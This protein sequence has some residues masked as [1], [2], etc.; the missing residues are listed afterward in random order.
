MMEES[1][2]SGKRCDRV[3]IQADIAG[4]VAYV[5]RFAI[6]KHSM[7]PVFARQHSGPGNRSHERPDPERDNHD[8]PYRHQ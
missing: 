3:H 5:L 7:G 2:L 6:R 8:H 1:F 4:S